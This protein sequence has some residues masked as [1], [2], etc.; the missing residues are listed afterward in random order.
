MMLVGATDRF[1]KMP[2]YIEAVIQ[3]AL[4]SA[5]GIIGL[6]VLFV[7]IS[8]N[9]DQGFLF[10]FFTITFLPFQVVMT[11][12]LSSMFAGWLGCHVSLKQFLDIS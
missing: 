9:V 12:I 10:G 11:I 1:I 5:L 2:F 3:G 6:L 7:Y 4:G 8:S